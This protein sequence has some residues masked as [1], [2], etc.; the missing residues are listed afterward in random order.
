VRGSPRGV[1]SH[2]PSR[3]SARDNSGVQFGLSPGLGLGISGIRLKVNSGDW[4]VRVFGL[5]HS[6]V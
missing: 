5:S 4:A 1:R 3:G 6:G 2:P